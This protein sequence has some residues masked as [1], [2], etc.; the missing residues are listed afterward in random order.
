[1]DD[2]I[3]WVSITARQTAL[4]MDRALA[5]YGLNAS[6]YMY[7]VR[8]CER[9][10]LTQDQFLQLFYIN[11]SN[12]TRAVMALEKQGFLERCPNPRD[13]RTFRLYPTPKAREVYP[14]ILQLRRDWQDVLLAGLAP[15]T[16]AEVEQALHDA[17]LRAVEHNREED[18]DHDD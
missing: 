8:I 9:P 18:P 14:K 11:P 17:A 15:D 12:V 16:R 3:K 10:G 4:H 5:P 2:L 7:V 13:R 6:Q 1:M